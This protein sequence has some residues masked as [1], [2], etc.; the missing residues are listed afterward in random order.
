MVFSVCSV[1]SVVSLFWLRRKLL[2]EIQIQLLAAE[3]QLDFAALAFGLHIRA[4]EGHGIFVVDILVVDH[5][6]II[7]AGNILL[8]GMIERN[9]SDLT[10]QA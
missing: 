8:F 5:G 7:V 4:V 2:Q 3:A 6:N 9:A 1:C 10:L